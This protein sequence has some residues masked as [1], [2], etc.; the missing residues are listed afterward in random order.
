MASKPMG[1]FNQLGKLH[2][3]IISKEP[4]RIAESQNDQAAEIDL[5]REMPNQFVNVRVYSIFLL[6]ISQ[7]MVQTDS[8]SQNEHQNET[9]RNLS[10]FVSQFDSRL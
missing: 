10:Q 9:P 1:K 5:S 7:Q 3:L 8:Q 2:G 4:I 6:T